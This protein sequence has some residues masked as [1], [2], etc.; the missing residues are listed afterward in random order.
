MSDANGGMAADDPKGLAAYVRL[1]RGQLRW[2]QGLLASRAGVSLSTVQR[3]ERGDAVGTAA[4]AGIAGALGLDPDAFTRS[5][6]PL[7]EEEQR[8]WFRRNFGW[9]EERVPV[10]VARLVRQPQLRAL[11]A[12]QFVVFDSDLGPV[13]AEDLGELREWLDLAGFLRGSAEGVFSP[14]PDRGVRM[15]TL[16]RDIFEHVRTIETRHRAVC[17]VGTYVAETDLPLMPSADVGV[18]A[19]RSRELNPAA[20]KIDVL[21]AER[22][23]ARGSIAWDA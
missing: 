18:L 12:T 3:V 7:T 17:L 20:G 5:R 9:L 15:R 11:A 14:P 2:K 23:I 4:L 8:D 16:Y 10:K 19:L 22:R 1:Q 13:V 6:A 21:L